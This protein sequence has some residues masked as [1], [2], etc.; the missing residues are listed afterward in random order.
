MALPI[1]PG[2]YYP[3]RTALETLVDDVRSL[4]GVIGNLQY[5]KS[6]HTYKVPGQNEERIT[7]PNLES[8]MHSIVHRIPESNKRSRFKVEP[9]NAIR[10]KISFVFARKSS[11]CELV[12][13]FKLD[14]I[15]VGL[16]ASDAKALDASMLM[17]YAQAVQ[18]AS[19]CAVNLGQLFMTSISTEDIVVPFITTSWDD[20]QFGAVY[21]M[22]NFYPS[23]VLLSSRLS[24]ICVRFAT[25]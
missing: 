18:V 23:T 14:D 9:A 5:W 21:M 20:I 22:D 7:K 15:S 1:G 12:V 10:N 19:D 24:F 3:P 4:Q 17:T 11:L 25:G 13:S 8:A 16:I 2:C 6:A